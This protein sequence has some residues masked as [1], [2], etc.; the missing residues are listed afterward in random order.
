MRLESFLFLA[1]TAYALFVRPRLLRW[2]ATDEEVRAPFPGSEIIPGGKRISTMATTIDAPPSRVWPW[3]VQMGFD[4]AGWYSWD[5]LDRAG[6]PS[7]R[8]LHAEWQSLSPGDRLLSDPIGPHWFEVAA[9]EPG[10]FL[11]LRAAMD[12]RGRQ[13]DSAAPRPRY[14]ND[15]LW[16][17]ELEELPGGRTRLVVSGYNAARPRWLAALTG[18]LFWEPAHWIMQLRQFENLE[19]RVEEHASAARPGEERPAPPGRP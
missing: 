12:L 5:L 2:G 14:F 1:G 8:H 17:F 16:A 11:G 13:Y 9:L 10:R 7:A 15:A 6:R 18:F 3:L 4:R 19:R